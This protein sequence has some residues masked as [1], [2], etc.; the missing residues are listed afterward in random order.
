[1][2]VFAD[3]IVAVEKVEGSEKGAGGKGEQNVTQLKPKPPICPCRLL[4]FCVNLFIGLIGSQLIPEWMESDVYDTWKTTIKMVTMFC[5]SYIMIHVGF[6]FDIDR[7]QIRQYGTEYLVAM[8][9]AGFPWLLCALW[10]IFA[11]GKHSLP[12]QEA[13]IAARFAAPTSA[14]IL[15]TMLEAAGMKQTWIFQKARIL[16]IFDD[17]DTLLL[18][19]PLKAIYVGAKWEL[20][21]DFVFVTILC[22]LMVT[23][24]H[25]LRVSTSW[26]AICLYAA[27]VAAVCELVHFLTHSEVTDPSDL[28]DTIHLEVLL[29]AFTVGCIIKHEHAKN[30]GHKIRRLDSLSVSSK[31]QLW[32]SRCSVKADTI[33]MCISAVFMVLVGFSMPALFRESSGDDGHRRLG[34]GSEETMEPGHIALHVLVCSLLMNLGKLFPATQYRKE[35]PLRTRIALAVAM[36]P[37]GEVCA[38]IIANALA[39]GI[40][41]PPMV[42]AIFCLATN[43]MMVSGFIF[44]VKALVAK[45]VAEFGE[46]CMPQPLV[47]DVPPHVNVEPPHLT[48]SPSAQPPAA[49]SGN[50]AKDASGVDALAEESIGA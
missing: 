38:G 12:W 33:K 45:D 32:T 1:M 27:G 28:A 2:A 50:E 49:V 13:L 5:V 7:T 25:R 47:N 40:T 46:G 43:M 23:L 10:F 3:G 9:A 21:V 35:A 42:I 48:E 22:T 24:M 37:R 30:D 36:M 17:L 18:M 16:A 11:L 15:F 29:P 41:G 8:T 31:F 44:V 34:G 6:E 39:L 19:V 14:G 4:L 26:P 20:I